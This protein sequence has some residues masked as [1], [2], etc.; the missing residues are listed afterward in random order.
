MN[1]WSIAQRLM[2]YRSGSFVRFILKL[3]YLST[4]LSLSVMIIAVAVISGF[5]KEIT[6]KIFGFWGHI[7]VNSIHSSQL[8]LSTPIVYDSTFTHTLDTLSGI[9]HYQ[10]FAYIPAIVTAGEEMEGLIFKGVDPDFDWSFFEKFLV[11]GSIHELRDSLD[12]QLLIS[13]SLASRLDLEVGER[14]RLHFVIDQDVVSRNFRI[15]GIYNT[16]LEEYDN[17]LAIGALAEIRQ[18]AG[19][20]ENQIG[21]YELFVDRLDEI[22]ALSDQIYENHL[23]TELYVETIRQKFPSIFDWLNL[24]ST[25]QYVIQA[26]MLLVAVINLVTVLLILI[27][28]RTRMIGTLKALGMRTWSLKKIFL[29]HGIQILV[30]GLIWG[31]AIGLL[32]CLIQKYAKV[33][34]LNEADYYLRVAPI[35]LNPWILLLLNLGTIAVT[36]LVLWIPSGLV[37][38]ISPLKA[39][40]YR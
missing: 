35:H 6:N 3:A 29:F 7:Q 40:G 9:R 31:N 14:C 23:G 28:E 30:R 27:L 34:K 19:W 33:I 32:V 15:T 17:K 12:R 38:R 2:H 21:G 37:S 36:V 8:N 5:N 18:L 39:I 10:R 24:Q 26:L 13:K 16:G 1:S 20:T 11:N 4:A 22:D 25:N